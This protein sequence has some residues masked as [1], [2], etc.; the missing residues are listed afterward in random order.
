MVGTTTFFGGYL[1]DIKII[2]GI[3]K[4]TANFT[5]V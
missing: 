1:D 2:K 3:A 4:Y 5:P